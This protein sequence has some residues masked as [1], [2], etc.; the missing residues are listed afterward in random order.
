MQTTKRRF[1]DKIEN[2]VFLII[3]LTTVATSAAVYAVTRGMFYM[4]MLDS[5]RSRTEI[6]NTYA[7]KVV[8]VESCC[9]K[10]KTPRPICISV[11]RES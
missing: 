6:V 10:R 11:N 8:N 1:F 2:K 4:A 3:L 9:G 5:I 7:Q